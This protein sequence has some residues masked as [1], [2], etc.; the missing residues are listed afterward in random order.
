MPLRLKKFV[1][2]SLENKLFVTSF[3]YLRVYRIDQQI[4]YLIWR[5]INFNKWHKCF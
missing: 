3:H 1:K 4:F 5:K 2:L